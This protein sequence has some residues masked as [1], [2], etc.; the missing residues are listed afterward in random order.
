MGVASLEFAPFACSGIQ[1]Q[2]TVALRCEPYLTLA[3]LIDVHNG[4]FLFSHPI[5]IVSLAAVYV[6]AFGS[7]QPY[8]RLAVAEY[9]IAAVAVER[10]VVVFIKFVSSALAGIDVH[11]IHTCRICANPQLVAVHA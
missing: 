1:S 10:V 8:I 11:Y 3:V 9:G 2:Y 4:G 7:C 6:N 5:E